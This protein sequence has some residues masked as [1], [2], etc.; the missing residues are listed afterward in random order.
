[1]ARD[2]IGLWSVLHVALRFVPT[3]GDLCLISPVGQLALDHCIV[4]FG[5]DIAGLEIDNA[6]SRI[7]QFQLDRHGE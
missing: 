2:Q 6:N 7:W 5:A 4:E 1:M 3:F